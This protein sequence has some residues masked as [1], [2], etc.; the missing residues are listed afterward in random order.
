MTFGPDD[1][2]SSSHRVLRNQRDNNNEM[3]NKTE[4]ILK[5]ESSS[6]SSSTS[7]KYLPTV[8]FHARFWT[9]FFEICLFSQISK[10]FHAQYSTDS[11]ISCYLVQSHLGRALF[12]LVCFIHL[13]QTGLAGVMSYMAGCIF[14]HLRHRAALSQPHCAFNQNFGVPIRS[15]FL[16][17]FEVC[18][19]V[20]YFFRCLWL[21]LIISPKRL[22]HRHLDK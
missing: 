18:L 20:V 12:L 16:D 1:M 8:G 9:I 15:A 13:H 6:L 17:D 3:T 14:I 22:D 2:S 4:N 11:S 5:P 19:W 7:C 21:L 10:Q